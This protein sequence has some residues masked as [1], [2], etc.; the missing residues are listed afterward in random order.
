FQLS[1][2]F[3]DGLP[4]TRS[5][6]HDEA[7]SSPRSARESSED[8]NYGQEAARHLSE[9]QTQVGL[10]AGK[11]GGTALHKFFLWPEINYKRVTEEQLHNEALAT[12]SG[13]DM[14]EKATMKYDKEFSTEDVT[15]DEDLMKKFRVFTNVHLQLLQEHQDLLSLCSNSE[16]GPKVKSMPD[17]YMLTIRLWRHGIH[18]YLEIMRHHLPESLDYM[19]LFIHHSYSMLANLLAQAP[20]YEETWMECLGDLSRY[21]MAV[22]T[23]D[24]LERELWAG[25]AM[26]W[27]SRAA[28]RNPDVGKFHHHLG[29]IARHDIN[30]KLFYYTKSLLVEQPFQGTVTSILD[31]FSPFLKDSEA[32]HRIPP[33]GAY[34]AAHA[35][36]F[37]GDFGN[38]LCR[39]VNT[40]LSHFNKYVTHL[41]QTFTM[42]GFFISAC[43]I[44]AILGYGNQDS[45]LAPEFDASNELGPLN[46]RETPPSVAS[47]LTPPEDLEK[48]KTDFLASRDSPDL[49]PTLFYGSYMTYKTISMLLDR[50][51]D[52]HIY[53]ACHV[54][55]AFLWCL[56]LTPNG[57]KHM[58]AVVPWRKIAIFLNSLFRSYIKPDIAE[59]SEFPVSEETTWVAED[60]LI[61][62]QC[63]SQRLY[64]PS[65]F[66]GAPSPD[67]GRHVE[68][69]SRDIT[70][71]YRCIWLGVRLSMF[72]RWITYDFDTRTFSTTSFV[73]DLERL[74]EQYDPFA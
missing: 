32:M 6:S 55:L 7:P 71:M 59:K 23:T 16:A 13:L 44:A 20:A 14:C 18:D 48:I 53:A 49:T 41:S 1:P 36:L 22:E 39:S 11:V 12:Y 5:V 47:L 73:S 35:F 70:R 10:G 42:Q 46:P 21:R 26:A 4:Q 64:P 17:T 63:W 69:P 57:M 45:L 60:F 34:I 3:S 68:L 40:F 74:A 43:N 61:R 52:R 30:Q 72:K 67:D 56:A 29:V 37:I 15:D 27:Y 62:G 28:D 31:I 38:K 19:L 66:D 54:Y 50:I 9:E 65:F 33:V 58:E 24:A 2:T 8:I 51:G 25:I